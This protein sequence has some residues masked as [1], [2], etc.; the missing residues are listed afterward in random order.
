MVDIVEIEERLKYL[1][2]YNDQHELEHKEIFKRL[3]EKDIADAIM[4]EQLDT[5]VKTT[6]R[7][8]EK[9]DKQREKQEKQDEIPK[10]RWNTVITATI[11]T[12]VGAVVGAII[13]LVI[14]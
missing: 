3:N 2:K 9:I 11:T 1:E 6:N 7:I 13:G 12:I 8:E 5:V 10:Q 14:K 4:R